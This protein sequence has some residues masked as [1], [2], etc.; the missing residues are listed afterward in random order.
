MTRRTVAALLLLL[1][2]PPNPSLCA[3]AAAASPPPPPPPAAG[4]GAQARVVS[5]FND[6]FDAY[7]TH[8]FPADEVFPCNCSGSHKKPLGGV[9]MTLVRRTAAAALAPVLPAV[10]AGSLVLLLSCSSV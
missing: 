2:L 10:F 1:L 3:A 6:A 5:I 8:A 9:A 7:M 4:A